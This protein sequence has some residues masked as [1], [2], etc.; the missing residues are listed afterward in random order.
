MFLRGYS[1][2]SCRAWCVLQNSFLISSSVY[3]RSFSPDILPFSSSV[4]SV[5][6]VSFF[7]V[8]FHSFSFPPCTPLLRVS[9]RVLL[10]DLCHPLR[11]GVYSVF[12]R[13]YSSFVCSVPPESTEFH[14]KTRILLLSFPFPLYHHW[15]CNINLPLLPFHFYLLPFL[16]QVYPFTFP[17]TFRSSLACWMR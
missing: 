13:G 10:R 1:S 11:L 2:L 17:W 4:I 8:V 6:A 9:S 16:F 15:L 14:G 12:L 3:Q 7:F 5:M